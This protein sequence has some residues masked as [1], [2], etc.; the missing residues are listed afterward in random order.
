LPQVKEAPPTP[1]LRSKPNHGLSK[2]ESAKR[3]SP[4]AEPVTLKGEQVGSKLESA[5]TG[6]SA[7]S[8]QIRAEGENSQEAL[9]TSP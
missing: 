6:D 3:K 9:T 7:D 1:N 2:I 4:D 8:F 5:R